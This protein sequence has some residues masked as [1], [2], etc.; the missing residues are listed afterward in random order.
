VAMEPTLD[1]ALNVLFGTQKPPEKTAQTP[2]L[3]PE[4]NRAKSQFEEAQ[5]AVRQ[6]D[7]EKFGKAMDALKR[8]MAEPQR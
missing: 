2:V 3:Q 8:L 1:G 5:K 4:F 7:W 6:G